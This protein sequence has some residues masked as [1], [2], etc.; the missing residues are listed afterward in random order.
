MVE[1]FRGISWERLGFPGERGKELG[2]GGGIAVLVFFRRFPRFNLYF[3]SYRS[4]VRQVDWF[5]G[6]NRPILYM[7]FVCHW[8]LP[9]PSRTPRLTAGVIVTHN[10]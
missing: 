2:Q 4:A 7:T 9:W 6:Y 10:L 3:K 1:V 5:F 8:E